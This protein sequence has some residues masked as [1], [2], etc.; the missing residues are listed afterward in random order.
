MKKGFLILAFT[1]FAL[2]FTSSSSQLFASD[3]FSG[4]QGG[5]Q[6]EDIN[7]RQPIDNSYYRCTAKGRTREGRWVEVV[8]ESSGLSWAQRYA[9]RDCAKKGGM[10]CKIEH[11]FREGRR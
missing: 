5:F 9:L 7:L 4:A 1:S 10:N 11:C 8:S 3:T 6:L 2:S